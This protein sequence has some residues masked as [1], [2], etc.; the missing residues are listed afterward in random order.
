MSEENLA[1]RQ[2]NFIYHELR[3]GGSRYSY[4]VSTE[5]F[6][7][8][9]SL[10]A[11]M[12]EMPNRHIDPRVTFDDGHLSDYEHALPL[13]ESKNL[14]ATFFITAGWTGKRNGY[15][16][17]TEIKSLQERGHA[18]GAH[19]L[20]H[21]LL[22]QCTPAQLNSE[23]RDSK[24][25][26]ENA[27]GNAVNTMSLP[28]GR[29]NTRVISACEDAGYTHIYT[30][31]PQLEPVPLTL[32]V[33][34]LNV[35]GDTQLQWLARLFASNDSLLSSLRSRYRMKLAVREALGDNLYEKLWGMINRKT[36]H[37]VDDG[38]VWQ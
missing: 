17:W 26:L 10:F 30:S 16:G 20:T 31:A 33:G 38:G 22:T 24:A 28:G 35:L 29:Y 2:L 9:L 11:E 14:R 7:T 6:E 34:R 5:L 36:P 4:V 27:L 15:M 23:L 19:G 1:P 21:M 18:I 3:P 12:R 32:L 13:L 25:V 8:H 37:T